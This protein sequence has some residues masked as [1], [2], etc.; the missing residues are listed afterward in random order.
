M[1]DL[2][3]IRQRILVES[4]TEGKARGYGENYVPVETPYDKA[5]MN[6]DF[7]DVL[8]SGLPLPGSDAL[9]ADAFGSSAVRNVA[10]RR[11]TALPT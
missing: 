5:F 11:V 6:G 10:G 1:R 8:V 4:I 2:I 3:G 7:L 9:T